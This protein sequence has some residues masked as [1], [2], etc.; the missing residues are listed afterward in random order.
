MT[1]YRLFRVVALSIAAAALVSVAAPGR[2]EAGEAGQFA[3]GSDDAADLPQ[4]V[5]PALARSFGGGARCG[6]GAG[7][8]LAAIGCADAATTD[9]MVARRWFAFTF[10]A[11]GNLEPSEALLTTPTGLDIAAMQSPFAGYWSQANGASVRFAEDVATAASGIDTDASGA[12]RSDALLEIGVPVLTAL[13][14][15]IGAALAALLVR[16]RRRAALV[17]QI[18][19]SYRRR[20]PAPRL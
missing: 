11:A 14:L 3:A 20:G 6:G 1:R 17:R 7:F 19:L 12:H 16:R 10:A 2:A 18:K 15:S 4:V 5:E 8:D 13:A 9:A